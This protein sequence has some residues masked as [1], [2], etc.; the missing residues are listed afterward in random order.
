M[1]KLAKNLTRLLARVGPDLAGATERD[2]KFLARR[3]FK[4]FTP[5]QVAAL[6]SKGFLPTIKQE[7][8]GFNKGTTNMLRGAEVVY[9]DHP[10]HGFHVASESSTK[11]VVHIPEIRPDATIAEQEFR[12]AISRHE[13]RE[14]ARLKA[15]IKAHTYDPLLDKRRVEQIGTSH[16]PGVIHDERV[17]RSQLSN[18][19]GLGTAWDKLPLSFDGRTVRSPR[20]AYIGSKPARYEHD[21]VR[22]WTKLRQAQIDRLNRELDPIMARSDISEGLADSIK[23]IM[24]EIAE[25][26]G[27]EG[28]R[29]SMVTFDDVKNYVLREIHNPRT[30][31]IRN[32]IYSL[33]TDARQKVFGVSESYNNRVYR[34]LADKLHMDV[35]AVKDILHGYGVP[36][37]QEIEK[38]MQLS[39]YSS[40]NPALAA[41]ADGRRERFGLAFLKRLL[42]GLH[43]RQ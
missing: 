17:F 28:L 6:R 18:R 14:F 1:Q 16:L 35:E 27:K 12:S 41:P 39:R 34:L 38:V 29:P 4:G 7:F 30:S 25:T 36:Q 20:D 19:L 26:A 11:H 37:D 33:P 8:A 10:A 13:A 15:A 2:L 31:D 40:P 23:S 5:K 3:G 24:P 42:R 22:R 32:T 21:L 9:L 43:K